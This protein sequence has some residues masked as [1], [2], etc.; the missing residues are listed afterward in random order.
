VRYTTLPIALL[1]SV[2]ACHASPPVLYAN[3]EGTRVGAEPPAL[4][5]ARS[6]D[7][8]LRDA[9]RGQLVVRSE[10]LFQ[11]NATAVTLRA[12]AGARTA[13]EQSVNASGFTEFR[14]LAPGEYTVTARRIGLQS[15]SV[16]VTIAAGFADT[17][18]FH[19]GQP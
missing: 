17:V 12:T 7:N 3:D 16:R 2:V 1:L 13:A 9:H 4:R 14:A 10:L 19:L 8:S 11:P 5:P 15:Q 18:V 6:V